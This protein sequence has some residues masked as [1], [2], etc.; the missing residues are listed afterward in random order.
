MAAPG[1][2]WPTSGWSQWHSGSCS[3]K[4]RLDLD[5]WSPQSYHRWS[6]RRP[7]LLWSNW[8]WSR[9]CRHPLTPNLSPNTI[10]AP[11]KLMTSQNV[12]FQIFFV[13]LTCKHWTCPHRQRR[14]SWCW[15]PAPRT[16]QRWCSC[17]HLCCCCYQQCQTIIL[18]IRD[19]CLCMSLSENGD[20]TT[21]TKL[22][23]TWVAGMPETGSE[24]NI[25]CKVERKIWFC[26]VKMK[27][28][29]LGIFVFRFV[30]ISFVLLHTIF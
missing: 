24:W 29:E 21:T 9:G 2:P 5:G 20:Y 4:L 10:W 13:H 27:F 26:E 8:L 6:H 14:C 18:T 23:L 25:F 22:W 17:Q 1:H 16:P 11:W 19:S 7:P 12:G 3:P 30:K 15:L 28:F